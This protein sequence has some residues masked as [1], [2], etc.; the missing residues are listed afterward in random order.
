MSAKKVR[1]WTHRFVCYAKSQGNDPED[2][3]AKDSID[4][5]G[6]S[7][8]GYILWMNDRWHEFSK[9]KGCERRAA[10]VYYSK[11]FDAWLAE[12]VKSG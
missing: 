12:K 1:D 7:M 8:A 5:P 10:S 9:I 11:E 4:Y 2:Q 3:L 6:G